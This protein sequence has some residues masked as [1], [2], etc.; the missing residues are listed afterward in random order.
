MRKMRRALTVF[1]IMPG[2]ERGPMPK[3]ARRFHHGLKLRAKLT[4]GSLI[5]IMLT[6]VVVTVALIGQHFLVHDRVRQGDTETYDR[7]TRIGSI[8]T[9]T[10]TGVGS[11]AALVGICLAFFISRVI[12]KGVHD[13]VKFAEQVSRGDLESRMSREGNDELA[14]LAEALNGMAESLLH[15]RLSH[16]REKAELE[17]L[18]RR[19]L[20][21][22]RERRRV[23]EALRVA[24]AKADD[25]R[26]KT[27]S[28]IS[29]LGDAL[30]IQDTSYKILFQNAISKEELGDHVGEYCYTAFHQLDKVCNECAMEMS[31]ADGNIHKQERS[32]AP[33][34]GSNVYVQVSTSPLR[35]AV[36]RIIAG[37][38]LVR[39]ISELKQREEELRRAKE[40][41][42]SASKAKSQFM[43]NMSH[44]IRTPMHGVIGMVK[45][46]LR[47]ELD[48]RQREYL[49]MAR[50][51][52]ESLLRLLNDIMDFSKIEAGKLD[53]LSIAF[54]LEE[55]IG[56]AM[57]LVAVQA[58][59]KDIKLSYLIDR[60]IP[61]VLVG[62][63]GRL[64]QV[65]INL[66]GNAV[67]FTDRGE[68]S[69]LVEVESACE[70][71]VVLHFSVSDSGIGIPED[72]QQ[73]IFDAFTQADNSTTRHFGGS[74]LGLAISSR[75]VELMGGTIRVESQTG[76]G[77]TFHFTA[78]FGV[79][80]EQEVSLDCGETGHQK[81]AGLSLLPEPL[82]RLRVL[83]AE[84]NLINR[85]LAISILEERG[86]TVTVANNGREAISL[87]QAKPFD[88]ILMDIQMPEVDGIQATS[89]IRELEKGQDTHMPIIAMTAHALK[90]DQ[91][92]CLAAGMDNYISKPVD[93]DELIL[94]VEEHPPNGARSGRPGG[95]EEMREI[96]PPGA[97][98]FEMGVALARARGKM[99]LLREIA[100]LFQQQCPKLLSDIRESIGRRDCERL[101]R[102]AHNLK[103]SVGNFGGRDAFRVAL[104]ME[105]L[106]LEGN[107]SGAEAFLEEME[108]KIAMLRDALSTLN[109]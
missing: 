22:I 3:I 92:R 69:V 94:M 100:A 51:S 84:D 73:I 20:C 91:Q 15:A 32:G 11:G 37:I 57:G 70:E 36:G 2:H 44:E 97:S 30:T 29:A 56:G 83:L 38:E 55:S 14:I 103:N 28:I 77:S 5:V 23:E 12:W 81:A 40:A 90:D 26:S 106:A 41:A 102:S 10:M 18:N 33:S 49:S 86:H 104:R 78:R 45:L 52:A 82:R 1:S 85:K 61:S 72:K 16:E 71:E 31:F 39:D 60:E 68:V 46:A 62:D 54:N 99:D 105:E 79:S 42:E 66:L 21:E 75:L 7:V 109:G 88:L 50:A 76:Q 80:S 64:G 65:L 108:Q 48:P 47:T 87:F 89:A 95:K 17:G 74:G 43:A 101:Q 6:M 8:I 24:M 13:S 59:S 107:L 27:E 34:R 53:L 25:E 19:L 96:S 98:V 63:P 58:R 67:K 4:L 93:P 9:W 35:D